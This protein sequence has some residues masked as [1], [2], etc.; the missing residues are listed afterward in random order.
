MRSEVFSPFFSAKGA[1]KFGVIFFWIFRVP[2]FPAFGCTNRK[3]L[4]PAPS[5]GMCRGLLLYQLWRILP[6]IFLEDFSG[7]FFPQKWEE[8][9]GERKISAKNSFC[10]KPTLK[11]ARQERA[12]VASYENLCNFNTKIWLDIDCIK[13]WWVASV[14]CPEAPRMPQTIKATC[15]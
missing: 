15:N 14:S 12:S 6:G 1:V 5:A 10:Q 11:F 7:H 2:Y 9:S 4:G 3:F 13:I 8:K